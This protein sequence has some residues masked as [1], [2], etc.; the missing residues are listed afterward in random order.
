MATIL[1]PA[2]E[3]ARTK[4]YTGIRPFD[5]GR[6]LR[7]VAEL[8]ADAFAT[9]LDAG[10]QAALREMRVMGYMG[11]IFGFLSRSALD[12]NN[13]YG[14]FVW[15]EAGRVIGNVT[16]QKADS[17]GNRWQIANVAV[18]PAYR[19]RG[20]ARQLVRRALD[21]AREMGGR[22]TVLQVRGTNQVALGLYERMG[23]ENLGGAM[24]W[25]IPRAPGGITAPDV[26]G[27]EPFSTREWRSLYEIASSQHGTQAQWW[28]SLRQSDF[29]PTP[30]QKL[31]E[32]FFRV[33]GR[34][35]VLRR[36]VAD[37]LRRF[38]AALVLT[39]QR[40]QGIH[41]IQLWVRP[42]CQGEME[43]AMLQWA[44]AELQ[45]YPRLP[46]RVEVSTHHPAAVQVLEGYGFR[47]VH[48]L[49][50]MRYKLTGA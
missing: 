50:T 34:Q 5:M 22:W 10:G 49:L 37:T 20:I 4:T 9:E 26:P 44:L 36:A 43:A 39:G 11:T 25:E 40:W 1:H 41:E 3:T 7:P 29:R 21:Y 6:D 15:V 24:R 19:G 27:L 13:A 48:T 14:G 32:W 8:I 33:M 16:V 45:D 31:G 17:Y 18:D 42:R 35:T 28:R 30:E 23:F 2:G 47:N 46:V 12:F 38:E